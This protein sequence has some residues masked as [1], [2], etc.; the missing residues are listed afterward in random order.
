[1]AGQS[2][3][4]EGFIEANGARIY[5]Q[6]ASS[7]FPLVLIHAGVADHTMW[8]AQFDLFA[9][10]YRVIRY[11]MR[12]FGSS[13]MPATPFRFID[14]LHAVL[15]ALG[16]QRT[17]LAGVSI[18]GSTVIDYT[19]THPER[20]AA[21]VPTACGIQGMPEDE[22]LNAMFEQMEKLYEA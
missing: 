16:V 7:G 5:Y 20:V 6:E 9:Q 4:R 1:M 13:T 17:Y 2:Q 22:S 8:D 3:R 14:D 10:Q 12:G 15:D 21:L 19:L 11:D 18:G